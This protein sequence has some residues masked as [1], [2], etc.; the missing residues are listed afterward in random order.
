MKKIMFEQV[1]FG[2]TIWFE[3]SHCLE[4]LRQQN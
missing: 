3:D 1:G 2:V 4:R